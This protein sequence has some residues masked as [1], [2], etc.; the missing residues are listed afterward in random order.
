[1]IKDPKQGLEAFMEDQKKKIFMDEKPDM[2]SMRDV[3]GP[4]MMYQAYQNHKNNHK[5]EEAINRKEDLIIQSRI[6]S[7]DDMINTLRMLCEIAVMKMIREE[8]EDEM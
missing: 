3:I 2:E 5:L 8:Q 4:L 6:S 7:M 1:M